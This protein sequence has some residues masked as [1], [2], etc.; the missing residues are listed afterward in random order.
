MILIMEI[1]VT[2]IYMLGT[3]VV[4]Q[5]GSKEARLKPHQD[6]TNQNVIKENILLHVL[7]SSVALLHIL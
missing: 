2:K 3:L 5:V 1:N 6:L 7:H 4:V